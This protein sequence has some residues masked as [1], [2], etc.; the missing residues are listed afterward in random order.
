MTITENTPVAE[1]ASAV[2]ASVR[3]LQSL[4]I[5]FCCGG[6][7]P[8]GAVCEEQ[9]LRFPEVASAIEA[10]A[11]APA[12]DQRDWS[13]EPLHALIDHII[14][15]Y[16]DPL[17]AELPR[18]EG[19]AKKVAGVHGAK[20]DYLA[21][22]DDIVGELS[23]DLNAHMRKE[24]QVLFPSIRAIE[25]GDSHGPRAMWI[26]APIG[27][28]EQEHDRAGELLAELRRLTGGYVPPEW[29]C[30][31]VRAFYQGLEEMEAAMH[32]HVHLENNVLFPRA[33]Q[34]AAGG[35]TRHN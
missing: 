24:E 22:I 31:T 13:R 1:I 8:I 12:P 23:A 3:V 29:G 10:A 4:G 25:I 6:K 17:R 14:A 35:A 16:H 26:T 9:G 7:R 15:T 21:T 33:L 2:P 34:V 11:A 20:A 27:V 28:M 30:Q 18:L 5:D 32:V 19:M